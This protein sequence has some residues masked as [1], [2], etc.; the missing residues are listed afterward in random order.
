MNARRSASAVGACVLVLC[1]LG[2]GVASAAAPGK[3]LTPQQW[4]SYQRAHTAFSKTTQ[5]TVATFRRCRS[6][7]AY[8]HDPKALAGCL[9]KAP[10]AELAAARALSVVLTSFRGK[11]VGTCRNVLNAY[12][13]ALHLWQGAVTSVERTVQQG[14]IATIQSTLD[15]ANVLYARLAVVEK[16]FPKACAPA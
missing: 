12:L 15:N 8:S 11:V 13:G 1:V 10:Q 14:Q 4:T 2:A 3:R 7:T 5:R 9:G 6:N 16:Q